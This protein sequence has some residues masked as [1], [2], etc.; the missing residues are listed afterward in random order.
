MWLCEHEWN[1]QGQKHHIL[2]E[3]IEVRG[4]PNKLWGDDP[5]SLWHGSNVAAILG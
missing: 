2:G 3:C 1:E 5:L 4:H